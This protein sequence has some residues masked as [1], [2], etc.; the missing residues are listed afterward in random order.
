MAELTVEERLKSL[1][2]LQ[3]IDSQVDELQ[4]LKGELPIEVS[5]L[6]DEIVGLETRTRR[7]QENLEDLEGEISRYESNILESKGLIER[8]T[9]QSE[10]VKNN[11]EFEALTKE[12]EMQHL[13]I[14]L[15]EKKIK[16]VKVG[17]TAKSE[18]LKT[19]QERLDLKKTELE[20][21]KVELQAIQEKT[22]KSEE[23]LR[24]K[25][26]RS[27][28]KI[29]ERLLKGYN[30]IRN[31]YRNGLAV[32]TVQRDSCGGCFNKVPPQ[33]QLEISMHKKV[34]VCEHCGRI[35]VDENILVEPAKA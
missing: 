33:T 3:L 20:R 8:Y 30:K 23:K 18:T 25:S 21:K 24:R 14:Q 4:I 9:K 11:R 7:L 15:A 32:V 28:K 5:D 31:N 27:K 2:Q 35:L 16:E 19:T 12:L 22:E 29:E 10:N 13:E 6:E 1:Y 34:I 26:E 17:K